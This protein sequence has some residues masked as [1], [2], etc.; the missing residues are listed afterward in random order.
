MSLYYA[1]LPDALQKIWHVFVQFMA[2]SLLDKKFLKM[3]MFLAKL[4]LR[5]L[6]FFSIHILCIRFNF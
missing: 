4:I 2:N 1:R 5:H 6:M 3:A